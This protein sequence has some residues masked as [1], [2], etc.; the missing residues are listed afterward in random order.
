M[1]GW[2][3]EGTPWQQKSDRSTNHI[4]GIWSKLIDTIALMQLAFSFAIFAFFVA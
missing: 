2:E 1:S 3:D 4:K